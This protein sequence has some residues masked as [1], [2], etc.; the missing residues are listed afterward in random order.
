MKKLH[1]DVFSLITPLSK[2]VPLTPDA[3]P[4]PP[5]PRSYPLKLANAMRSSRFGLP[6]VE[7][8][9]KQM[10]PGP[11][12]VRYLHFSKYEVPDYALRKVIKELD[13]TDQSAIR[14][15]LWSNGEMH[16]DKEH[17]RWIELD[18]PF[19]AET[20]RAFKRVFKVLEQLGVLRLAERQRKEVTNGG[21]AL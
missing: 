13:E 21:P 9:G 6:Q 12:P 8:L 16:H 17:R 3:P 20:E 5:V 1:F 11:S 10:T 19:T 14:A 4:K 7:L 15:Y 18:P 2:P